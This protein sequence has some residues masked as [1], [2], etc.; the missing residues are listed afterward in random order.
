MKLLSLAETG[1][2][3]RMTLL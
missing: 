2:K 3:I 1:I